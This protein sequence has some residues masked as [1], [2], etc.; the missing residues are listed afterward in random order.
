[1]TAKNK[2]IPCTNGPMVQGRKVKNRSGEICLAAVLYYLWYKI[3]DWTSFHIYG[4]KKR[5]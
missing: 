2:R 5:R 1:M 4:I 3:K